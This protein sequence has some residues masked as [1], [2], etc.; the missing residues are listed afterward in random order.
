LEDL[1][2]VLQFGA[3]KYE[4]DNWKKG[5]PYT[6]ISNS[7]LRHLIAFLSKET[8]DS[9]SQLPHTAHILANAMFLAWMEKNRT[10]FDD[11]R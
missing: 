8:L 10:E 2:R 4:V 3:D 7:L 1:I 9:E 5:L 6:E 11:R